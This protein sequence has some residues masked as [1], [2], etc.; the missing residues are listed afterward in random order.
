VSL[1]A[2]ECNKAIHMGLDEIVEKNVQEIMGMGGPW[3]GDLYLGELFISGN[4]VARNY[5]WNEQLDALFFVKRYHVNKYYGFFSINFYKI[6]GGVVF[7]F[8]EEFDYL[9]LGK[10]ISEHEIEIY[11]AMHDKIDSKKLVF[12]IN[13]ED[14]E[15]EK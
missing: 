1:E 10:F 12:N 13:E 4:V 9:C 7:R 8:N 5:L 3:V 2:E 6:K 15:I 14:F 11:R